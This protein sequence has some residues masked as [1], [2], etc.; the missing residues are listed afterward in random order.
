[1]I[2]L[3][4]DVHSNYTNAQENKIN[5]YGKK[6][7]ITAISMWNVIFFKRKS[8]CFIKERTW[9]RPTEQKRER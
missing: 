9:I 8:A 4:G 7:M 1:M 3:E 5:I 2:E 6:E